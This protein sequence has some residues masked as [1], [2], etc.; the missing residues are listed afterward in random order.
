[1]ECEEEE[2]KSGQD[3]ACGQ[4][5]EGTEQK[6]WKCMEICGKI[7]KDLKT[8]SSRFD[9]AKRA[10]LQKITRKQPTPA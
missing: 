6:E 5:L 3:T 2:G 10:S 8:S 7:L 4:I 1:M 9:C